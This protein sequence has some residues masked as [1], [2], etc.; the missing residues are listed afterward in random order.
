M[1]AHIKP[2]KGLSGR[3]RLLEVSGGINTQLDGYDHARDPNAQTIAR[4][5]IESLAESGV[6]A[7]AMGI[8]L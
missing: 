3:P 4:A 1:K 6:R 2:L 5:I 7:L 8:V